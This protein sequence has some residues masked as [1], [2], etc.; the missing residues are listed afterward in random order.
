LKYKVDHTDTDFDPATFK[1]EITGE[2]TADDT[3]NTNNT[4]SVTSFAVTADAADD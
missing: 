1:P 2:V 3:D 4:D